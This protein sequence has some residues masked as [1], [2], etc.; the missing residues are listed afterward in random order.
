MPITEINNINCYYE[1]HGEGR[2][3]MLIGGLASDSQ[4]WQPVVSRLKKYFQVI[5]FDNRGTGRTQYPD[6]SFDIAVLS[7]DAVML[8]GHLGIE[9]ADIVGHSMGGY[10]AQEIAITY[11]EKV[12]RLVLASTASFTSA[13]NKFLFAGMLKMLENDIPY[14]LFL[15]EFMYW[16]F[17]PGYFEDRK[18]VDEFI[19]CALDYPYRQTTDGFRKQVEA[20]TAYSSYDRS[21][22]IRAKTLLIAGEK[23]ILIPR[24]DTELL[25][26]RIPEAAVKYIEGA[27]H[28]LPIETP[29]H[30]VNVLIPFVGLV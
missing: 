2:P 27:A 26:G 14:A 29:E 10:I 8:L 15:K 7:K 18:N 17:T 20:Y 25:A 23:D 12:N 5:V 11:P 22:R 28:S 13:R 3:V 4:S 30:F 21:D 1:V 16:L 19:K 24:E 6:R 9:N